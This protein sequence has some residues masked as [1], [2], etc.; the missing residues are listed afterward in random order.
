[1][2]RNKRATANPSHLISVSQNTHYS[3]LSLVTTQ[4]EEITDRPEFF[5][6]CYNF[7]KPLDRV[8]VIRRDDQVI[9]EYIVKSIDSTKLLVETIKLSKIDLIKPEVII[10]TTIEQ[11]SSLIPEPNPDVKPLAKL[12]TE[13][14]ENNGNK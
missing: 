12:A 4:P 10:Y 6:K 5:G 13:K 14:E 1:M 2:E 3:I 7:L 9:I 11:N 8:Q